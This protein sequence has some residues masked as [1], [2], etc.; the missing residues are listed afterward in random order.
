MRILVVT[1]KL[2]H[3]TKTGIQTTGGFPIQIDALEPYFERITLCAPVLDDPEP[4]KNSRT[5]IVCT[6]KIYYEL[7]KRRRD[8]NKKG[9]ALIR[10]EQLY[11]FDAK[12]FG[13]VAARYGK[14]GKWFWVQEEPENMGAWGFVRHRL[15]DV[16]GRP[17]EFIGRRPASSP[18]TGFPMIYKQEQEDI[19]QQ[20]M[21]TRN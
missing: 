16:I 14:A 18:A 11:P 8:L 13:Q 2:L 15:A 4:F 20:A 12:R 19:L 10:L 21:G 6:G 1:H 5:V 17:V 7:L 9:P 3:Q